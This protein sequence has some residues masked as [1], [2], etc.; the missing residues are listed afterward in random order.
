MSGEL[1]GRV[2][3]VT[4][5]SRGIGRAIALSLA[6]AGVDVAVGF[7]QAEDAAKAVQR[8]IEELGRR[9]VV[10]GGD[11]STEPG[12]ERIVR[13]ARELGDL[14]ILV[15]N[16]GIAPAHTLDTLSVED[17]DQVLAA[18]LRSAFLLTRALVPAMRKARFG[19]ILNVSSTAAQVGGVV[20]PHYAAS[21]AGMLGLTH[22]YA[23]QLASEGITVNA[24]CPALIQ[25][26]MLEQL[27][28]AKPEKIP[29]GRFGTPE[30]CAE[31]ALAVLA[32][33][34]VTGQTIQVN[35]GLYPT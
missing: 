11:V 33:G 23:S 8:E 26:D 7:H 35:G 6:R 3:L 14:A 17:F 18:N 34:Y 20:G 1:Q 9:A 21:K 5:A 32:N 4:G 31:L 16:A 10:A 13:A 19:R 27:P 2:A 29:V 28:G 30:E 25:T 22:A 24:L 15:N 12:V